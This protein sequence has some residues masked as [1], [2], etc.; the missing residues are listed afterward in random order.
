MKIFWF[1]AGGAFFLCWPISSRYPKYR[2]LV[3]PL[4]WALWDIPTDAE[5]AFMYLRE[6]ARVS[7]E[8]VLKREM[9]EG[10]KEG[11]GVDVGVGTRAGDARFAGQVEGC[12]GDGDG[13]ENEEW[14]TPPSTP[15]S[16]PTLLAFRAH[17]AS[18]SGNLLITPTSIRFVTTSPLHKNPQRELFSLPFPLLSE[19]RKIDGRI[20]RLAKISG[21]LPKRAKE[22]GEDLLLIKIDAEKV[23]VEGVRG[24]DEAF[25][26]I[27]G[28]S[29]AS[30]VRWVSLQSGGDG[31]RKEKGGK[32]KGGLLGG[33]GT[34]GIG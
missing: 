29:G 1:V 22:S 19:M 5:A 30:G 33:W 24:R 23:L 18:H 32:G 2:H 6:K 3:S 11:G 12:E 31:E 27:L 10:E 16:T 21:A 14:H 8:E 28:F 4:K 20:S 17:H 9:E 25:N 34:M 13:D 7:R 26:S 15:P